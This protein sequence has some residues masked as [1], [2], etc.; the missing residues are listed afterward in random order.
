MLIYALINYKNS[1]NMFLKILNLRRF[2]F[3]FF[4][5]WINLSKKKKKKSIRFWLVEASFFLKCMPPHR[6]AIVMVSL[7]LIYWEILNGSVSLVLNEV[8][9]IIHVTFRSKPKL[10]LLLNVICD[11]VPVML[12]FSFNRVKYNIYC[13]RSLIN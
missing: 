10:V 5:E 3:V 1:E 13:T 8:N 2:W 9:P 6:K 7:I 4:I 11:T 12:Y